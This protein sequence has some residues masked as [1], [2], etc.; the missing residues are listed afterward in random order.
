MGIVKP[1]NII[2]DHKK[3][4]LRLIDWGLAKFYFPGQEYIARVASWYLKGPELLLKIFV[5][6]DV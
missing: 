4:E 2:I 3:R 1:H 5:V 6:Y